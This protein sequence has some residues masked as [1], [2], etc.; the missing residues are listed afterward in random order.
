MATICLL[1]GLAIG[2]LLRGSQ[3]TAPL[4]SSNAAR[5]SDA[6]GI[7]AIHR[8]PTLEQMKAMAD[9]KVDPLLTQLKGDPVNKDLP[10]QIASYYKSAHLFKDAAAY[11]SRATELD[12]KNTAIRTEM[13]SCLYFD[14]NIEGALTTLEQS[15]HQSPTDANALFNLGLIRWKGKKDS[16]GAIAAWKELL[17]TNPNLD[18]KP[19]VERMI[20][21]AQANSN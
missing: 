4:T 15:L 18:K 6:N 19:L 3:S 1:L 5:R 2:Y 12:P 20:E 9:R 21:E 17:K 10:I 7:E 14:G 13:A 11:L 16:A 8:M